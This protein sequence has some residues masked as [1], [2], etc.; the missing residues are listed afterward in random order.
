MGMKPKTNPS[1]DAVRLYHIHHLKRDVCVNCGRKDNLSFHHFIY[2]KKVKPIVLCRS[3]HLIL[4]HRIGKDNPNWKN[5]MKDYV[6]FCCK[7]NFKAREYIYV[8]PKFCSK[9]CASKFRR[10]KLISTKC[11]SCGK[12]FLKLP[13]RKRK[14]CC[15]KCVYGN[16]SQEGKDENK[17]TTR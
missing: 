10:H 15:L 9:K 16:R 4:Y 5:K 13:N 6:C 14:F 8:K 7:K 3:C 17:R 11:L 12:S 2:D 1:K